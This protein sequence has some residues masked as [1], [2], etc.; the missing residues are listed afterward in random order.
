[1]Q[2]GLVRLTQANR[3]RTSDGLTG[4]I[5]QGELGQVEWLRGGQALVRFPED[6]VTILGGPSRE[7]KVV[8][9]QSKFQLIQLAGPPAS[10]FVDDWVSPR[11][12]CLQ[13]H[14]LWSRSAKGTNVC[15]IDGFKLVDIGTAQEDKILSS[16]QMTSINGLNFVPLSPFSKGYATDIYKVKSEL[17]GTCIAKVLSPR[18][19]NDLRWVQPFRDEHVRFE[20]FSHSNLV[21]ALGFGVAQ[22]RPFII[23]EHA[24]GKTLAQTLWLHGSL[25]LYDALF[26]AR[27]V[28]ETLLY[29]ANKGLIYEAL[30]P[31]EIVILPNSDIKL[32]DLGRAPPM[33]Q[34]I[35]SLS[36]GGAFGGDASYTAPELLQGEPETLSS[37]VYS[38]GCILFESLSGTNP[39]REQNIL[40]TGRKQLTSA[41]PEVGSLREGRVCPPKVRDFLKRMIAINPGDRPTIKEVYQE[42]YQ[43]SR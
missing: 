29:L 10:P 31:R 17:Y 24:D 35:E 12:L 22:K 27:D 5:M 8:L 16:G 1:M 37:N 19:C 43:L 13:C 21:K 38:L 28:A 40:L 2:N 26:M 14:Q 25:P 30:N 23:L 3:F 32:L 4:M 20:K 18:F 7:Q 6:S 41:R 34:L 9:D 36:S 33:G 42:L 39:F 11:L 15:P